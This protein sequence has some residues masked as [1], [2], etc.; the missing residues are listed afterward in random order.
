MI[1]VR[2]KSE[3]HH[4]ATDSSSRTIDSRTS[5]RFATQTHESLR[6]NIDRNEDLFIAPSSR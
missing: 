3:S 4:R 6:A 2:P 1:G 5:M